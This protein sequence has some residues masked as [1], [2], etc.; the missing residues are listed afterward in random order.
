MTAIMTRHASTRVS[1][2]LSLN[3]RQVRNI[4]DSPKAILIGQEKRGNIIHKLFW[5]KPD[6]QWFVAIQDRST[7]EIITILSRCSSRWPISDDTLTRA[8]DLAFNGGQ[9]VEDDSTLMERVFPK[10]IVQP[11][12][13]RGVSTQ[14]PASTLQIKAR[15]KCPNDQTW[16]IGLK[17]LPCDEYGSDPE[18]ASKNPKFIEIVRRQLNEKLGPDKVCEKLSIRLGQ[19]G[20][21][22]EFSVAK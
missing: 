12:K 9:L 10:K 22:F 21:K 7:G 14:M 16:F 15:I 1:Q 5:S 8:R 18:V 20:E 13:K 2:R 19:V 4:M 3:K 11:E 17:S 6:S